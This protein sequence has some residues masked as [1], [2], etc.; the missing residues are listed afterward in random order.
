MLMFTKK[1]V[2]CSCFCQILEGCLIHYRTIDSST[3][4]EKIAIVAMERSFTN[5]CLCCLLSTSLDSTKTKENAAVSNRKFCLRCIHFWCLNGDLHSSTILK[6][7]HDRILLFE[8]STWNITREQGS[9]EL[10]WIVRFEVGSLPGKQCI[11]GG[12]TFIKS[13]PSEFLDKTE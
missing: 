6:V 11:R 2:Q 5:D 8:I 9:H 1:A 10:G 3:E 4:I 12:M 13:V 7:L